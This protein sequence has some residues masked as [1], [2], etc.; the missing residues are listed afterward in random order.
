LIEQRMNLRYL[1]QFLP[2]KS[3]TVVVNTCTHN[4][5]GPG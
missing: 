2:H 1:H 5:L 3:L 4:F